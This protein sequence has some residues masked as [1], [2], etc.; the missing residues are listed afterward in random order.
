MPP[1]I[2]ADCGDDTLPYPAKRGGSTR[3]RQDQFPGIPKKIRRAEALAL[4]RQ[5]SPPYVASGKPLY[6]GKVKDPVGAEG[7]GARGAPPPP[8]EGAPR[9]RPI[10]SHDVPSRA[11]PDLPLYRGRKTAP[12]RPSQRDVER[13][14]AGR[15]S[16]QPAAPSP[17]AGN[18]LSRASLCAPGQQPR[19]RGAPDEA[20][21][22]TY[23][24]F[25]PQRTTRL[26]ARSRA[27]HR[28]SW[29]AG[30]GVAPARTMRRKAL[31]P[32]RSRTSLGTYG[33]LRRKYSRSDNTENND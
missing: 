18:R 29:H 2:S 16:P 9:R 1:S 4:P 26:G 8:R 23:P 10:G 12:G 15:R 33:T 21:A 22:A 5:P 25:T 13:Q 6:I 14:L 11:P 3:V 7:P 17:P 19:P 30:S 28:E 27:A 32:R 31:A 24:P 20:A